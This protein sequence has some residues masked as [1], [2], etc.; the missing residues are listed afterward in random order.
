MSREVSIDKKF[1]FNHKVKTRSWN[2]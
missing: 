1:G 2:L